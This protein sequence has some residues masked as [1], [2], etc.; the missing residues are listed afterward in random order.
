[1]KSFVSSYQTGRCVT[2]EQYN[3]KHFN[4]YN[5]KQTIDLNSC[6]FKFNIQKI[7]ANEDIILPIIILIFFTG[8]DN[9][10]SRRIEFL[11]DNRILRI[12]YK[13]SVLFRD[14]CYKL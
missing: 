7:E 14:F 12:D 13:V 4:L 11:T 6:Q 2:T 5:N 9:K 1:M 8:V 3:V 10:T